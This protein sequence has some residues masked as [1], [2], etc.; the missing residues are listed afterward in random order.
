M[1]FSSRDRRTLQAL[2]R[3]AFPT[4]ARAP[5]VGESLADRTIAFLDGAPREARL[6][7]RAVLFAFEWAAQPGRR[8]SRLPE[9]AARRC[10]ERWAHSRVSLVRL[11]FRAL[12]SP[13]K[14]VHYGEPHV[15]RALGYDP[16]AETACAHPRPSSK[17][18]S[19]PRRAASTA[20]RSRWP[21][22]ATGTS[23]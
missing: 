4:G 13:L 7:L 2:A 20:A 10:D 8:F 6:F 3:A 9:E 18:A 19:T 11:A 16:P 15:A 1:P 23:A 22:S 12:I 5:P 21:R 17:R 14:L